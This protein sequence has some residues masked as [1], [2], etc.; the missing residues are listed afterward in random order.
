MEIKGHKICLKC[1]H[2]LKVVGVI[3]QE[4]NIK[5]FLDY[6]NK[7]PSKLA[8]RNTAASSP[9]SNQTWSCTADKVVRYNRQLLTSLH[10][11][12]DLWL[13]ET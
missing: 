8:R 5:W 10:M 11:F 7:P 2:H 4:S 6:C 13:Y 12:I 1:S 9:D 3:P